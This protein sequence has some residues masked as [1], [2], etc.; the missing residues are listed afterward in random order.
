VRG[1]QVNAIVISLLSLLVL[2]FV[3]GFLQGQ[4]NKTATDLNITLDAGWSNAM[5]A[6]ATGANTI[7]NVFI[8]VAVIGLIATVVYIFMHRR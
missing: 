2:L 1:Q 8:A 3:G 5:G 4:L 7:T 6:I